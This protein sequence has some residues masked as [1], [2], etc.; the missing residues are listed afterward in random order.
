MSPQDV[1]PTT[2]L[3]IARGRTLYVAGRFFEAHEAWEDAW[4]FESGDMRA[5]LQ[6]LIHVAAGFVKALRDRRPAGA[7][8]H[9]HSA[10]ERLVA[11]PDVYAGVNVRQ[12]R[13]DLAQAL[14]SAERWRD[15][16]AQ[17]LEA[18]PPRLD[19]VCDLPP[20]A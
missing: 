7:V 20:A 15:G 17:R 3:A 18:P 16:A 10:A 14:A 19:R 13:E 12:L 2:R 5:F 8:K 1:R 11:F 9:F 6:A 4:R